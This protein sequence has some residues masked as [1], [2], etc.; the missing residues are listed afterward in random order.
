MSKTKSGLTCLSWN[1]QKKRDGRDGIW[2]G[3]AG[4]AAAG[5]GNHNYC[6]NPQQYKA[7]SA[8]QVSWC[9]TVSSK[10][11]WETC[12]VGRPSSRCECYKDAKAQDYR[13]TVD[14]TKGGLACL[15]WTRVEKANRVSDGWNSWKRGAAAK[16]VGNHN[17]CR[18]PDGG[19]GAWCYTTRMTPDG[20]RFEHCDVGKRSVVSCN[21][22]N[23]CELVN[24]S[25]CEAKAKGQG[26]TWANTA[27]NFC[28]K[29]GAC[30]RA[31]REMQLHHCTTAANT[32][33]LTCPSGTF[34]PGNP[35]PR[36]HPVALART[37]AHLHSTLFRSVRRF[38]NPGCGSCVIRLPPPHFCVHE[39]TNPRLCALPTQHR[40]ATITPTQPITAAP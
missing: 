29:C 37:R 16:G 3:T 2:T 21:K 7:G 27:E 31:R 10:K 39:C 34:V 19:S 15:P 4:A 11:R 22:C 38:T 36:W 12:D 35:P 6:R 28:D 33:C 18:N 25:M 13:G 17:F 1:I 30:R 9:Y 8:S 32:L 20:K 14:T 40:S 26:M 24:T 5:V 23:T